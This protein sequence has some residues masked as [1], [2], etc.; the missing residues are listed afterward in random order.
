MDIH[1]L[2]AGCFGLAAGL[3]LAERDHDVTIIDPRGVGT[4]ASSKAAG[5]VS[6]MTWSDDDFHLVQQT[7]GRLG[8]LIA[9]ASFD[10]DAA[11]GLWRSHDSLTIARGRALETMDDIQHRVERLGEET[12]RLDHLQAADAYPQLRFEPGEEVLIAQEDGYVEAGDLCQV[13]AW[14][15][16]EYGAKLVRQT[17]QRPEAT[18]VAAGAWTHSLLEARGARM[19]LGSF[20]VQAASLGM[21]GDVPIVHDVVHGSYFRPESDSTVMAG[22]GSRLWDHDPDDYDESADTE[23]RDGIAGKIVARV[24]AAAN[25]TWR[26][27]WAGLVVGTPDRRPVCGPVPGVDGLH[28]L[29]G[30][31]GFGIMRCVALGERLADAIDAD[32]HE[33][34]DPRRFAGFEGPWEIREGFGW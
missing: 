26:N 32:V 28:V 7:R 8:Q 1:V 5:I 34:T 10:V 13:L 18:V 17:D 27:G 6:T 16:Q 15:A 2:G 12:E 24:P 21:P 11:E 31:N 9:E 3:A 19:P 33:A 14:A 20:R 30:D 25:A 4:G 22:N 29:S 23:F